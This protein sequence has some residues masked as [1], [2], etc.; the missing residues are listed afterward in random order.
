MPIGD[1][2]PTP[3]MTIRIGVS[4]AFMTGPGDRR[5][6]FGREHQI[7]L[8]NSPTVSRRQRAAKLDP[9]RPKRYGSDRSTVQLRRV[10]RGFSAD[11]LSY[12]Q[13]PRLG[14]MNSLCKGRTVSSSSP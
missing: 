3:V 9:L 5:I 8:F 10:S 6:G 13:S 2:T 12:R 11:L 14:E 7:G 1:T 4:P